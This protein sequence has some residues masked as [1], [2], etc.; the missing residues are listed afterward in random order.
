ML[1]GDPVLSGGERSQV[2]QFLTAVRYDYQNRYKYCSRSLNR[3][4]KF[5]KF[6]SKFRRSYIGRLDIQLQRF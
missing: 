1:L 6:S 4:A 2:R 3:Q 5:T